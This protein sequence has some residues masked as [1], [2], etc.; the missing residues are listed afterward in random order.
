MDSRGHDA[1]NENVYGL[2]LLRE[3][4][5]EA[6][7]DRAETMKKALDPCKNCK[8]LIR[9]GVGEVENFC[10]ESSA[11]TKTTQRKRPRGQ[12]EEQETRRGTKKMKR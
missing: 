3:G 10:K 8:E 6:G 7:Y 2:T 11:S 9:I 4:L 1:S 5:S 12:D